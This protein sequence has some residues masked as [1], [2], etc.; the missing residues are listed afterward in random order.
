MTGEIDRI[1]GAL[2]AERS[3]RRAA[4]KRAYAAEQELRNL[5][6]FLVK[7]GDSTEKML[8]DIDKKIHTKEKK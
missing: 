8:D 1:H 7:L 5:K 4:E 3:L 6:N 2:K